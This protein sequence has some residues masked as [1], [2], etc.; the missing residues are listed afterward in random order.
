MTTL[1][2]YSPVVILN[3]NLPGIFKVIIVFKFSVITIANYTTVVISLQ[4]RR[5]KMCHR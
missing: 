4:L 1:H 3:Q 5:R 2:I